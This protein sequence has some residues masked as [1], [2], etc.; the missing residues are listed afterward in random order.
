MAKMYKDSEPAMLAV[1]RELRP[2]HILILGRKTCN[3]FLSRTAKVEAFLTWHPERVKW[4][5]VPEN[6]SELWRYSLDD[7]PF[8]VANVY[9]PSARGKYS[10]G[11][12]KSI[13]AKVVSNFLMQRP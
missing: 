11:A 4:K 3:Y 1:L 10:F 2:T 6:L 7:Q 9:H 8:L 5:G 13:L 12:Q